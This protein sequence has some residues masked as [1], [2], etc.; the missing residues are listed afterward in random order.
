MKKIY[1]FE[2]YIPHLFE[3]TMEIGYV[4]SWLCDKCFKKMKSK[5]YASTYHDVESR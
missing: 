4:K 3:G 2:D 1:Q 5:V